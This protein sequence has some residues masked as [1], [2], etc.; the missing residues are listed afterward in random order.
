[1]AVLPT[2]FPEVRRTWCAHVLVIILSYW[3]DRPQVHY[4]Y[5]GLGCSTVEHEYA[6]GHKQNGGQMSRM[7]LDMLMGW[8]R[9]NRFDVRTAANHIRAAMAFCRTN[10]QLGGSNTFMTAYIRQ[11]TSRL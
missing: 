3:K 7:A 11:Q 10:R 8:I 5:D 1:M 4:V 9:D 6:H 2:S